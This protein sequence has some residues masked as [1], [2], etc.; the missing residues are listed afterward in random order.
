VGKEQQFARATVDLERVQEAGMRVGALWAVFAGFL[1][2]VSL[3]AQSN[4]SP[5]VKSAASAEFAPS[6]GLPPCVVRAVQ[7]GD[8]KSGPSIIRLRLKQG[9]VIPWHWHTPNERLIVLSGTLKSEM[10]DG[11]SVTLRQGDFFRLPS[12]H[13]HHVTAITAVELFNI[14]DAP[15]D[16]HY[17]DAQGKEIPLASG[18]EVT[19]T[20]AAKK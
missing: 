8:P 9:C 18:A 19:T 2:T 14:P 17:V 11:G 16:I 20:P 10:K 5:V 12:K 1:C 13:I 4:E 15:F 7:D 6:P 3:F